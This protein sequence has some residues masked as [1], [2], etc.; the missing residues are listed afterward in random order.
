[1]EN[2]YVR[3]VLDASTALVTLKGSFKFDPDSEYFVGVTDDGEQ[4]L[5]SGFNVLYAVRA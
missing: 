4:V 2:H 1:M 5:V 3:L